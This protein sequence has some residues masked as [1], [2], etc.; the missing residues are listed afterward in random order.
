MSRASYTLKNT[1]NLY[2]PAI[3]AK[4]THNLCAQLLLVETLNA[5]FLL[6]DSLRHGSITWHHYV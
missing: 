5:S 6:V 2:A 3:F 1:L 4:K